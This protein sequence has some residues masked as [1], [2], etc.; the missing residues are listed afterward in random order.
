MEKGKGMGKYKL[1]EKEQK[2]RNIQK[3]AKKAKN[4]GKR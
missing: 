3:S 4:K 2:L 1:K